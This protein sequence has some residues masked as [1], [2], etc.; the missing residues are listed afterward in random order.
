MDQTSSKTQQLQ[1]AAVIFLLRAGE[2]VIDKVLLEDAFL[3]HVGF[4]D[5]QMGAKCGVENELKLN[6]N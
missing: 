3:K 4:A 2:C 1:Q 5:V 6:S